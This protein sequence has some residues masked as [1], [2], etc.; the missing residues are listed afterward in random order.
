VVVATAGM[1]LLGNWQLRR[2]ES[3][4]ELSWAYTFE[5]PLFSAFTIF[6]WIKSL[7]DELRGHGASASVE[8]DA[9][10]APVT[11]PT[12]AATA[13]ETTA[14]AAARAVE[15]GRAA[16]SDRKPASWDATSWNAAN[17]DATGQE[18]HAAAAGNPADVARATPADGEAYRARLMAEVRGPSRRRGRR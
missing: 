9:A 5:W 4:N 11:G 16:S 12:T 17:W 1:L 18:A 14:S 3:G 10:A 7:R 13:P 8:H 6:F 2:A 15:T